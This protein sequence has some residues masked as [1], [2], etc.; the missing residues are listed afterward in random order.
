MKIN[1]VFM[2]YFSETG[3]IAPLNDYLSKMGITD[4]EEDLII[5]INERIVKCIEL[6]VQIHKIEESKAKGIKD[7]KTYMLVNG[8]HCDLFSTLTSI[9]LCA[10][11]VFSLHVSE[12]KDELQFWKGKYEIG[13]DDKLALSRPLFTNT[14]LCNNS[15]FSPQ[16][17]LITYGNFGE[18][19]WFQCYDNNKT[20][21]IK[22]PQP[23]LSEGGLIRTKYYAQVL[24]IP[25]MKY[26]STLGKYMCYDVF[27]KKFRGSR[28]EYPVSAGMKEFLKIGEELMG[29][30]VKE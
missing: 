10:K 25:L 11:E 2:E 9:Y 8:I 28:E 29:L 30:Y 20:S 13:D 23:L 22:A 4:K 14:L 24:L 15:L 27:G 19:V 3:F 7:V 6:I 12:A 1:D 21:L 18:G 26:L 5:S 17:R 16:H